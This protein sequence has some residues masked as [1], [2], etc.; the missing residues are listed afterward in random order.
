[1]EISHDLHT[2]THTHIKKA[3]TSK[4]FVPRFAGKALLKGTNIS[5]LYTQPHVDAS[6]VLSI[7]IDVSHKA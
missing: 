5:E 2:H 7:G 3:K 4:Q 6:P 1:M